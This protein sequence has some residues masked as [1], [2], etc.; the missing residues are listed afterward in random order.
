MKILVTSDIHSNLDA[1][2]AVIEAAGVFDEAWCLGDIAGYGPDPNECISLVKNLPNLKCVMGNHDL[3]LSSNR[4]LDVFN[5]EAKQ[6]ILISKKIISEESLAFLRELPEMI[7]MDIATL[8]HGSPQNPIWEY[9]L[10]KYT[11]LEAFEVV[12]TQFTFVGHSHLPI[13]FTQNAPGEISQRQL[14]QPGSVIHFNERAIL[15]P[16]SVGQPRDNDPRASFGLFDPQN[17]TWEICRVEYDIPAVQ[18]R[19][20]AAGLPARHA[21]RLSKG[22]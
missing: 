11:A 3:A 1:L 22:W 13:L 21:N 6:A 9:I 8:V 19:I 4:N 12:E 20:I 14:L 17:L 2:Q 18:K 16:G 7:S 5:E 10:E 15:N